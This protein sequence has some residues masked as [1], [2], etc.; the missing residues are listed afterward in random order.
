MQGYG[1]YLGLA[2]GL[3]WQMEVQQ[4]L[5]DEKCLERYGYK[6]YSQYDE[7]GILQEI[8]RRIGTTDK[9]FVEFGVQD[10]LECNSHYLLLLGW[11][12][13]WIE[14]NKDYCEGIKRKFEQV[15]NSGKLRIKE[16]FITKENINALISS[17]GLA[18]EIDFLSID[19]D[20]NDYY[21]WEE[22]KVINP[23]VCVLNI[24]PN[25]RR[26]AIGLCPIGKSIFGG[27]NDYFGASLKALE[28]LGE[29]KGYQL[30]GTNLS[31]INAF[32]VRGDLAK[33]LFFYPPTAENLYNP[34]RY[35]L[36]YENG[37]PC[38]QC[39]L[40]QPASMILKGDRTQAQEMYDQMENALLDGINIY[41]ENFSQKG[42]NNEVLEEFTKRFHPIIRDIVLDK[43]QDYVFLKSQ[44]NSCLKNNSSY[45]EIQRDY[46]QKYYLTD[47]GGYEVY[48][49]SKGKELDG[50]LAPILSVV[51]DKKKR[52]LDIGCGRGELS[53]ALA[54][55]GAK[56]V[57][58]D[59][60]ESAICLAKETY[61]EYNLENLEFR[62]MDAFQLLDS[63]ENLIS[64]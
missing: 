62:C 44:G 38:F 12:G 20:G 15:I 61:R 37:H 13:L 11:S 10:G 18:G 46:D 9:S 32:F 47:C 19:I 24:T 53:F 28:R 45:I 21:I 48:K 17:A 51:R 41:I 56:V 63:G 30:V 34:P 22:I 52:I 27:G 55:T 25:F 31:G 54:R 3:K 26:N 5:S 39:V 33:D 23:R 16:S 36:T 29:T 40:G 6:V 2:N 60:S 8:F 35:Q 49:K 58:I 1:G 59:Y 7:D 57:G 64:Y 43:K 42:I 50:R 4:R 14:G